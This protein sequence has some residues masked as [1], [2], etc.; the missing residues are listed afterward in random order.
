MIDQ[1]Q[2]REPDHQA[3][4]RTHPASHPRMILGDL[5]KNPEKRDAYQ[6]PPAEWQHSL[7]NRRRLGQLDPYRRSGQR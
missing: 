5:W 4:T 2:Q 3:R 7:R 6:Q 1:P